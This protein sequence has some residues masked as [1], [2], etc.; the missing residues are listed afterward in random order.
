[1][2]KLR[3]ALAFVLA[4]AIC[5]GLGTFA[6]GASGTQTLT[7]P[8]AFFDYEYTF[9]TGTDETGTYV[10]T[11]VPGQDY[12]VFDAY[13]RHLESRPDLVLAGTHEG[14]L[15][16]MKTYEYDFNYTGSQKIGTVGI[17]SANVVVRLYVQEVFKKQVIF[18]LYWGSGYAIGDT[19]ARENASSDTSEELPD[20][21]YFWNELL[22][23]SQEDDVTGGRRAVYRL[24]ARD[25]DAA[26]EYAQLLDSGRFPLYLV[27]SVTKDMGKGD[28]TTLYI[29]A[30]DGF[31]NVDVVSSFFDAEDWYGVLIL[32][33]N[34]WPAFDMCEMSITFA[35]GLTFTDTG[36]RATVKVVGREGGRLGPIGRPAPIDSAEYAMAVGE[37]LTLDCPRRF[38]ANSE[39]FR[40]SVL[41]DQG[42]VSLDGTISAS[43]T[44]TA[45]KPGTVTVQVLYIHTYEQADVLTGNRGYG[46]AAP[47][48]YFTIEIQ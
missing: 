37:S 29:F 35:D 12:T 46:S 20:P 44:V 7:D 26:Y 4:L 47:T 43:C 38:G 23:H 14:G 34:D 3:G 22:T 18:K 5:L 40:W 1:M 41:D 48:Y 16:K 27:E 36:D 31:E 19:G 8:E 33:I 45:L 28:T 13:I 24:E 11:T 32:K 30:Y 2:R 25:M 10:S 6:H 21:Y 17:Y 42:L 39:N 15:D 9:E